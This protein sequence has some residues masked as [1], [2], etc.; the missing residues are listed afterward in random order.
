MKINPDYKLRE[1]KFTLDDWAEGVFDS[2]D[3]LPSKIA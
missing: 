2:C 1:I 3:V